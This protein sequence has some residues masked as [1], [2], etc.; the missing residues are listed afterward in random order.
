MTDWQQTYPPEDPETYHPACLQW[1]PLDAAA[2]DG[3]AADIKA[4]G[5]RQAIDVARNA[6]GRLQ[7]VD[8]RSRLQACVKAGVEPRFRELTPGIDLY[9]W[10]LSANAHRRHAS[11]RELA[12]M[13]ALASLDSGQ[14]RQRG[15]D[16]PL[17]L[18]D[19]AQAYGV[20]P[21]LVKTQRAAILAH[22]DLEVRLRQ[23]G[24]AS[25][26]YAQWLEETERRQEAT[27][28][29]L[30]RPDTAVDLP[31]AEA[32]VE[33]PPAA[34]VAKQERAI[35]R[36]G[37]LQ[38]AYG[39]G[40]DRDRLY[41]Q[42]QQRSHQAL[43]EAKERTAA[44]RP[45][46]MLEAALAHQEA[47]R[48]AVIYADPPWEADDYSIPNRRYDAKF[49]TLEPEALLAMG[50]DVQRLAAPDA[51]LFLWALPH[52]L[53]EAKA[54]LEAWGFA[55]RSDAVWVKPRFGMG[56]YLRRQY[57]TLLIGFR[58]AVQPGDRADAGVSNVMQAPP[59]EAGRHSSKPAAAYALI[60]RLH[61]TWPK[62]EL[63]ARWRMPGWAAYGN[64]CQD[65][66]GEA[67]W[68]RSQPCA[69]PAA[70]L[71]APM[72]LPGM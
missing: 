38:R 3:L 16:A 20:S 29:Q 15:T 22:A 69:A 11:K 6:Q 46:A 65:W 23:G 34:F 4:H 53:D 25:L 41:V 54:L 9:A 10:V 39:Q 48:F 60:E 68:K 55:L 5:L 72:T 63:F 45:T 21:R 35:R 52:R 13:A 59:L 30:P 64:E 43:Q 2:L 37:D 71:A 32:W 70:T 18:G 31:T 44:N 51:V 50:T 26:P 67:P 57:E 33:P 24:P 62:V 42:A 14:G 8:G 19:A 47:G 36:H 7:V 58:G 12:W 40:G 1:S 17:Q 56:S 27:L 61:P 49:P 28:A 66:K